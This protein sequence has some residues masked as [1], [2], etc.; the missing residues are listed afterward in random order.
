MT[1]QG[2]LSHDFFKAL[3]VTPNYNI[4]TIVDTSAE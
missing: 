4:R 3:S 1:I 2:A